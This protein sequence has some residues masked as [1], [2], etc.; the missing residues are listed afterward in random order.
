MATGFIYV[1]R[2]IDDDYLQ[3]A[4]CSVPTWFK[5]RIY[6][7]PCKKPMRP[8]MRSG[9]YV[10]GISH[11]GVRPRRIIF[12]GKIE[13]RMTFAEAYRRYPELHGPTGP[14]HVRPVSRPGELFPD[15][16]YEHIP[17]ANH[18]SDWRSDIATP[19]LDAFFTLE[20]ADRCVGR[21]LGKDG[22]VVAGDILKFLR[23]CS[24]HGQAGKL[25]DGNSGA[26]E[27]A[28][29][30][31]GNLYTGLHLE[32]GMPEQLLTLVCGDLHTSDG[33]ARPEARPIVDRSSINGVLAKRPRRC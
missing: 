27:S 33:G 31:Y 11:S 18:E 26:T 23:S 6:F 3:T 2:T 19:A 29:V 20:P 15:N 13:E 32:T 1:V 16:S 7:G 12:G 17:G 22:P 4:L 21:W 9:D 10:F 14:I 25:S 28:P 8:R 24:V 30:R 5:G